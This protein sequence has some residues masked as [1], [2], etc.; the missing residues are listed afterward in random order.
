MY[1]HVYVIA[2]DAGLCWVY[3]TYN[4]LVC[5]S[6]CVYLCTFTYT[7]TYIYKHIQSYVIIFE[8]G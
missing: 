4:I 7:Y 1:T 2:R 8:K 5:V 3:V 6:E